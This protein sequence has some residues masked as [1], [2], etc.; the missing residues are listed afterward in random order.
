MQRRHFDEQARGWAEAV[1][2]HAQ[3]ALRLHPDKMAEVQR[4]CG[5]AIGPDGTNT[6]SSKADAD[7]YVAALG[8]VIGPIAAASA[9]MAIMTKV[10][11]LHLL[12]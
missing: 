12:R 4:E 9:R 5:L 3:M 1:R 11:E 10:R 6:A 7:A 2:A 8:K